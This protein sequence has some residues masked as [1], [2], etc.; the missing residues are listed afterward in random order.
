MEFFNKTKWVLTKQSDPLIKPD[1]TFVLPIYIIDILGMQHPTTITAS[2]IKISGRNK[3]ILPTVVTATALGN[4]LFTAGATIVTVDWNGT[5]ALNLNITV[6]GGDV[7]T[8]QLV[9]VS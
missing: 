3:T 6:D 2:I 4:G 9:A 7:V 1:T 8:L 5:E